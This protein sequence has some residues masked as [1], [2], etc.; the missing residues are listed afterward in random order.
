MKAAVV[1]SFDAPP[2]YED[3][4]APPLHEPDDVLVDVLAAGLHPRYEAA[5][6]AVTT[7]TSVCYP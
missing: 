5:H 1:R 3:F 4:E 2:Q 6:R 7:P